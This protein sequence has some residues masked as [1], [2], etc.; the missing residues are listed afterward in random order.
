[1]MAVDIDP[2]LE[3]RRMAVAEQRARGRLRRLLTIIVVLAIVGAIAWTL[4]S[5]FFSVEHLVVEGSESP[6]VA[7][8]LS[9]AGVGLGTPLVEVDVAHATEMLE[10]DPRIMSAALQVEWPQTVWVLIE[11]RLPLAWAKVD[12]V[13]SRVGIDGVVLSPAEAPD[14][15]L[16]RLEVAADTSLGAGALEFFAALDPSVSAG[17]RAY[18]QDG[19]LWAEVKGFP[20]RLGGPVEMGDKARAVAAL[21][22]TDPPVGSVIT[23]VAPT[24]P[25]LMPPA[26]KDASTDPQVEPEG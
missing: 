14:G 21:V 1:M 26:A 24:R 10:A 19:E 22:N 3:A 23:V 5:P 17:A 7:D 25:A 8:I 16:P 11:E 6:A 12:G 9:A 13:W 18:E 20:V 15:T 2:R 4:R